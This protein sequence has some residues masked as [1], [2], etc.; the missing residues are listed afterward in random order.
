MANEV[1]PL[2]AMMAEAL[3]ERVERALEEA[4]PAVEKVERAKEALRKAAQSV[5]EASALPSV[6]GLA[7]KPP[8][9]PREAFRLLMEE[10]LSRPKGYLI[11]PGI[12]D[13]PTAWGEEDPL[14]E[15]E[16]VP[17]LLYSWNAY[18]RTGDRWR[19][20]LLEGIKR[21]AGN[22]LSAAS[23]LAGARGASRRRELLDYV[24]GQARRLDH[25]LRAYEA[26]LAAMSAL[27]LGSAEELAERVVSE[28]R[29]RLR[30]LIAEG[31]R[32]LHEAWENLYPRFQE[33]L[34]N[35]LGP[36][37]AVRALKEAPP[38]PAFPRLPAV[39][40][41]RKERVKRLE[42]WAHKALRHLQR[43]P[44][45]PLEYAAAFDDLEK[46]KPLI[47]DV[48]L[49]FTWPDQEEPKE[50]LL[51]AVRSFE[52]I[53]L[54]ALASAAY[55]ISFAKEGIDE[56]TGLG[57]EGVKKVFGYLHDLRELRIPVPQEYCA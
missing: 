6:E 25:L 56:W 20:R 22:I 10:A 21:V 42:G 1:P 30:A 26:T 17:R 9:P 53:R 57:L 5:G 28:A 2:F 37:G 15:W 54:G 13:L 40:E 49:A 47:F 50:K 36:G 31:E 16:G 55:G 34:E 4:L 45:T 7:L 12:P 14:L 35:L 32:F 29:S 48:S 24:A 41:E 43:P 52:G 18:A 46:L 27:E 23:N 39:H 51:S 44:Q 3:P 11:H 38:D 8:P 33:A 19:E